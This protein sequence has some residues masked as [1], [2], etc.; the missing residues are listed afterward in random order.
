MKLQPRVSD[1]VEITVTDPHPT[2]M[3][4]PH[5]SPTITF[6]LLPVTPD[7]LPQTLLGLPAPPVIEPPR[8]K[9]A[10][11]N[12]TTLGRRVGKKLANQIS[13]SNKASAVV[14]FM[15]CFRLIPIIG[16]RNTD[17]DV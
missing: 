12:T 4:H 8:L 7:G 16:M 10:P 17:A 11:Q 2:P 9:S 5:L 13:E 14:R 6:H 15:V 3:P 1:R